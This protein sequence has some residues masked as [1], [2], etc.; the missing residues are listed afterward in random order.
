MEEKYGFGLSDGNNS[1]SLSELIDEETL[2][3]LKR[4]IKEEVENIEGPEKL[5]NLMWKFVL[6]MFLTKD[7]KEQRAKCGCKPTLELEEMFPITF[8]ET[9]TQDV[10]DD[11]KLNNL[12]NPD[13]S[14]NVTKNMKGDDNGK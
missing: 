6:L 3:K 7:T 13:S 2:E 4:E 10:S 11:Y 1:K 8:L 9:L 5:A 14:E 12:V